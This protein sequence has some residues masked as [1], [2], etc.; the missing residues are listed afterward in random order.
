M[1]NFVKSLLTDELFLRVESCKK[2]SVIPHQ[3]QTFNMN[4]KFVT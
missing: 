1:F 3:N 4:L 2:K